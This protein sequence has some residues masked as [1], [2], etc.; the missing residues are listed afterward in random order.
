M[1]WIDELQNPPFLFKN[2]TSTQVFVCFLCKSAP[3]INLHTF[4]ITYFRRIDTL[5]SCYL[6]FFIK[7]FMPLIVIFQWNLREIRFS[8]Q[9]PSPFKKKLVR[10]MSTIIRDCYEICWNKSIVT[11]SIL[12][13]L[14]SK[15]QKTKLIVMHYSWTL[16]TFILCKISSLKTVLLIFKFLS[17]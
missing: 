12:N 8:W 11:Y 6:L 7:E 15:Y 13:I 1:L 10:C 5:S 14:I 17:L 3:I 9:I 2:L 16:L 4:H